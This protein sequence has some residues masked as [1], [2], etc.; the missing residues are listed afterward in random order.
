MRRRAVGVI[1]ASRPSE[2]ERLVAREVGERLATA[3][4]VVVTGGLGGVMEAAS[5]GATEK[6]GTVIGIVPGSD[7]DAANPYVALAIA[8]GSGDARNA[9]IADTADGFIAVGGGLGTLSEIALALKRGKPVVALSTW[10]LD[11]TRLEGVVWLKADTAE[12]AVDLILTHLG[13]NLI[14]GA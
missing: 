13:H 11:K 2:E 14:G 5:R 6:G 10:K 7:P 8:T 9:I 3:G 4:L 12:S 1:G